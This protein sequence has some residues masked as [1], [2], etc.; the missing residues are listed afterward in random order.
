MKPITAFVA[1]DFHCGHEVGLTPPQWKVQKPGEEAMEK[2]RRYVWDSVTAK[3]DEFRPSGGYDWG[4]YVGDLVDGKGTRIGGAE[5]IELDFHK[6]AEMASSFV[7]FVKAKNNVIVRG[8]PYHVDASG[9]ETIEDLVAKE[10]NA[11]RVGD[12]VNVK[13]RGLLV[14]LRHFIPMSAAPQSAATALLRDM[15]WNALWSAH[16]DFE[17]ADILIRAHTHYHLAVQAP[18]FLAMSLPGLQ[19]YGSRFG[20]RQVSREFHIGFVIFRIYSKEDWSWKATTFRFPRPAP[21]ERER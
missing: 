4:W 17:L 9:G 16:Q 1:S 11:M 15:V 18:G 20:E 3:V 5:A 10:V 12:V 19:G 2:Y 13:E 8:T 14:N 7:N 6:Q 21:V